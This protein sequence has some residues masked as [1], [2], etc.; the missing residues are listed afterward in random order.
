M[1]CIYSHILCDISPARSHSMTSTYFTSYVQCSSSFVDTILKGSFAARATTMSQVWIGSIPAGLTGSDVADEIARLVPVLEL[2]Y[3]PRP[4]NVI[5]N[6]ITTHIV[7]IIVQIS[8]VN[9]DGT[10]FTINL[11][12]FLIVYSDI[13]ACQPCMCSNCCSTL[14]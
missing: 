7:C 11:Q 6:E 8:C 1:C 12:H 10:C 9:V 2:K 13:L 4:G 3:R 14:M 5:R